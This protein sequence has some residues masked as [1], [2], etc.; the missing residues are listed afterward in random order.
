MEMGWKEGQPRKKELSEERLV[1]K[2]GPAATE[3][4]GL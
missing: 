3:L 2:V 1:C 4:E